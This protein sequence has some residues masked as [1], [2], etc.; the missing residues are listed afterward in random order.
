M[1]APIAAAG[2]P[3]SLR[4]RRYLVGTVAR[5]C[6]TA[7]AAARRHVCRTRAGSTGSDRFGPSTGSDRVICRGRCRGQV[8]CSLSR[9]LRTRMKDTSPV[10]LGGCDHDDFVARQP[11]LAAPDQAQE[12]KKTQLGAPRVGQ[13]APGPSEPRMSNRTRMRITYQCVS[14]ADWAKAARHLRASDTIRQQSRPPFQLSIRRCAVG[15]R[16]LLDTGRDAEKRLECRSWY[17]CRSRI[18]DVCLCVCV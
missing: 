11:Q 1:S 4:S 17:V 13:G 18:K 16:P 3:G 14:V 7:L 12:P 10:R 9:L 2:P 8:A 5:S 6:C 15:L